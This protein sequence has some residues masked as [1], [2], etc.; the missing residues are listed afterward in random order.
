M[1]VAQRWVFLRVVRFMR[2]A[3]GQC[4]V[5]RGRAAVATPANQVRLAEWVR[6]LRSGG[7]GGR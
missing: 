5:A 4:L 1:N 3:R 2:S 7:V 6:R